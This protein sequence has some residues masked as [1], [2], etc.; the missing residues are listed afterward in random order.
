M[1]FFSTGRFPIW[2]CTK[3]PFLILEKYSLDVNITL[4]I[5]NDMASFHYTL[6]PDSLAALICKFRSNEMRIIEKRY[7]K[8]LADF[9]Q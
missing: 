9:L 6:L 5:K 1:C 4:I 3:F 7:L 8:S 2:H